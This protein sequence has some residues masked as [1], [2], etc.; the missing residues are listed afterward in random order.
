MPRF[1]VY[2][3]LHTAVI[4]PGGRTLEVQIRTEEMHRQGG[5]RRR[6]ALALQEKPRTQGP[7]SVEVDEMSWMRKLLDWQ[8]VAA[9][10]GDFLEQLRYDLGAQQDLRLHAEGQRDHPAREVDAG[11]LRL[12]RAHRGGPPVT[13]SR[14]NGRLV[15]AAR[16]GVRRRRRDLHVQG[17]E[18][19]PEPRLA[20]VRRLTAG[21]DED[22][23]VVREG[24]ARG[25]HRGGKDA[26]T[27]EA[28]RT[29]D[30][31]AAARVGR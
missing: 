20:R 26:I 13:G 3:S 30:A 11:G 4:G 22:Q 7:A 10:P 27:R 2:Q 9:D 1:G 28:R 6:R 25:G 14:V 8:R 19:G 18:G 12:R 17:G 31:V 15:R 21:Q 5:V 23:A 24:A 29:W 16:A